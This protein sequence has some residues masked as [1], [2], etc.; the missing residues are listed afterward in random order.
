MGRKFQSILLLVIGLIFTFIPIIGLLFFDN[1]LS[2]S[3]TLKFTDGNQ[4]VLAGTYYQGSEPYGVILLEGFGSDQV[5]MTNLASEFVRNGWHVL[6][7]DFSGHGRSSGTLTFDNAQTDRLAKQT[8]TAIQEFTRI[9]GLKDD[10]IFLLGHSLGARVALQTAT[11]NSE[12]AGLILLG[13]QVNLSTNIQSE[14]FTGTSD[15]DLA[16][17]QSLDS[18]NPAVPILLISGAWD[19]ILT[20]NN[21]ELLFSKLSSGDYEHQNEEFH[22]RNTGNLTRQQIILPG[23][24]HNYEPFSSTVL[25]EIKDWLRVRLLID[26]PDSLRPTIRI[27]GWVIS[28]VG[29]FILLIGIRKQFFEEEEISNKQ[30][31]SIQITNLRSF[32]WGKVLLWLGALPVSAILGSVF[33]FIPIGKPVLNLIYVCFIGGYGI[34]LL[35]LYKLGKMPGVN[36]KLRN[37]G[38]GPFNFRNL[39]TASQKDWKRILYSIGFTIALLIITAAY[40]RTGW[41]FVFPIN[42]RLIW[43]FIFTPFTALGFWI[44]LRESEMLQKQGGVQLAQ[45]LIGLFP[46]FLNTILM[47]A[48]GSLSGMIGGLQGLVILWLVLTFGN[49]IQAISRRAWLTATCMA[50]LLYWLILPQSVLF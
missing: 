21:A 11:I 39:V 37:I 20:P 45:T 31:Q 9:S 2:K 27:W 15:N 30:N 48:L 34:L 29:V 10:R 7:F 42:L 13:T 8:L 19:D 40:T 1:P 36:G 16:W 47:A 5:T 24:V 23:L 22:S 32:L 38:K 44:G 3:Q 18:D 26:F 33:F 4:D 6:T 43:L 17:I 49:L 41:F 28:L 12:V 50:I 46:F 35:L 25:K 14:F